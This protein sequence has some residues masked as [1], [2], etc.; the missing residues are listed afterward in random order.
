MRLPWLIVP[1]AALAG[2]GDYVPAVKADHDSPRYVA[3]VAA[4]QDQGDAEA[5]KRAKKRGPYFLTYP[6]S[7]PLL[8]RQAIDDCMHARGYVDED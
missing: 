8:E 6:V 2:C 3:D 5:D 7:F 1:I 4:C